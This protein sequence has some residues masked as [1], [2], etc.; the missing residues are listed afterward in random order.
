MLLQK[1]GLYQYI[2]QNNLMML[3]ARKNPFRV[4]R[5][6]KLKY[7]PPESGKKLLKR[8][9]ENNLK[10]EVSGLHGF[11]KSSFLDYFASL[12]SSEGFGLRRIGRQSRCPFK[13][14]FKGL[15]KR[16]VVI[17]DDFDVMPAG[18]RLAVKILSGNFYGLILS[19]HTGGKLPSLL[20]LKPD[21]NLFIML[22]NKLASDAYSEDV[23]KKIF[24]KNSGNIREA[25]RELYELCSAKEPET[26]VY[27]TSSR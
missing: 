11:G 16:E 13:S 25:F 3:K 17:I 15:L 1:T 24:F 4:Y 12:L 9:K 10:G 14:L 6:E 2:N 21:V 27:A 22:T 5:I 20:E 26:P 18:F 19:V 7:C 8:F 23:L